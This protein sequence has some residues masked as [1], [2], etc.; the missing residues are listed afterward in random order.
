MSRQINKGD[1]V[2]WQFG[3][4]ILVGRVVDCYHQNTNMLD[5]ISY[6]ARYWPHGNKAL[7]VELEDGRKVLKLENEVQPV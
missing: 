1:Q 5:K 7:L 6:H 4:D 3:G 2:V